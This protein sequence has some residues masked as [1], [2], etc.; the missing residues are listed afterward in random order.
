M[1]GNSEFEG[2]NCS[3]QMN[4]GSSRAMTMEG[5][6]KA[7]ADR[8]GVWGGHRGDGFD[9]VPVNKSDKIADPYQSMPFPMHD[10][11]GSTKKG[12]TI[13]AS[14]TLEPG[15]Y[16]GGITITGANVVVKLKPGIYVM[17]DGALHLKGQ[18][19]VEG[20]EVMVAFTGDDSTLRVWGGSTVK[21]TSPTSGTY[22]N[23]QFFQDRTD[24]KGRGL[25]V[26]IG[27][28]GPGDDSKVEFD[29]AAYFPTQNFWVFGNSELEARSPGMAIVADKVWVQGNSK[30]K[31]SNANPRNL[32]VTGPKQ[33][34]SGVVLVR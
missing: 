14:T 17:V 21:L 9:P 28:N 12:L 31:V 27:G 18:A 2:D 4:S 5:Q 30:M 6:P 19:R 7:R 13:G 16:C 8:F 20:E 1:N 24:S 3:V 26:S 23:M 25:W 10:K 22:A 34:A 15:T 32:N 11:C 29:G 33:Y